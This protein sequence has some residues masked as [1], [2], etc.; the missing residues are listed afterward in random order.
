MFV[1]AKP[2]EFLIVG[3]RGKVVNKGAAG[4]AFLWP[5]SSYLLISST[6]QEATFEMTQE[7]RDGIPLR[8][9]GL[10]IYRIVR[11][12]AAAR[13]FDFAWGG[14]HEQIKAMIGHVCLGELRAVAAH[15]TM[16]ECIEERKTT[17]TDTVAAALRETIQGKGADGDWGIEVDV[18]Q[19]AQVFIVDGELR[20]Q[21]ESEVRNQ[22]K[23]SS[24]L[25]EMKLQ[26]ELANARSIT[27][28]KAMQ[29]ALETEKERVR[30]ERERFEL[31][32]RS[33]Q[34]ALRL[35]D[36]ARRRRMQ[37]EHTAEQERIRAE[38][39]ALR[40]QE[41]LEHAAERERVKREHLLEQERLRAE[42]ERRCLEQQ[43]EEERLEAEAPVRMLEIAKQIEIL[44]EELKMRGL[45]S[46]VKELE[47]T[48]QLLLERARHDLRKEI[49]PLEQVPQVASAIAG[50][51]QGSQLSIYGE[52]APLFSAFEP[53]MKLVAKAL[54]ETGVGHVN[55]KAEVVRN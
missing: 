14:G 34:E 40:E 16:N 26:E 46:Q 55:G 12:E 8:F 38:N 50:M 7:T 6:Q 3:R 27:E 39:E 51:L 33:D 47:I 20:R 11:P 23:A 31:R 44:T 30:I 2:N 5:G 4:S 52:A 54:G 18:V 13:L 53:A 17:L 21:L 22:I 32:A 9:K 24:E 15:M 28:R 37:F 1:K 35:E 45:E 48:G 25:S 41:E 43:L 42:H 36:E 49:L 19:V 10:V 29:E